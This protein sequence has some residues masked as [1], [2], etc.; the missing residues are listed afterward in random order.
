MPENCIFSNKTTSVT[1]KLLSPSSEDW[2]N[3]DQ[4]ASISR[5]WNGLKPQTSG[6]Q[7]NASVVS[8]WN[9]DSIFFRFS[10]RY[11]KLHVNPDYPRD[12]SVE[13][14]WDYDVAEVFMKPDGCPGYF[15]YEVSPLSQF[16]AAHIIKPWKEVDFTWDSG[17][18]ARSELE[19]DSLRWNA[20]IELPFQAMAAAESFRMPESGD[21]WRINLLLALG[22]DPSRYYMCW[23][24]TLTEQPDFHVPDAFGC[25][26]FK[27]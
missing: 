9:H 4:P 26:I 15:E 12:R 22:K 23:Q 7:V 16:L 2:K 27:D 8:L 6:P 5:L 17:M 13:G 21:I 18:K 24:P 11:E 1:E 3:Q 10:C 19:E 25:L 20:V 14:L